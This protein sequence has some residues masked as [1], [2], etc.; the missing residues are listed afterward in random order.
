MWYLSPPP[1]ISL[2]VVV[3]SYRLN[4]C[5]LRAFSVL[6]SRLWNSSPRLLRDTSHNT[7]A[8]DFLDTLWRHSFSQSTCAYSALGALAIV[9]YT[10]LRFT[11]LLTYLLS[12][13]FSS[14]HIVL[15][16]TVWIKYRLVRENRPHGYRNSK[17]H[18]SQTVHAMLAELSL[19]FS[20]VSTCL[21]SH[22]EAVGLGILYFCLCRP[23]DV[24][25]PCVWNPVLHH[26]LSCYESGS[27][28]LRTR[29][30]FTDMY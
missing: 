21:Y 2:F 1:V 26:M 7:T 16:F 20:V 29:G 14:L 11:Y 9:R 23:C 12:S 18:L 8:L 3:R 22:T 15:M 6:G 30:H 10:N 4:S 5:G 19:G 17:A 28:R 25:W 27:D 13:S 24:R